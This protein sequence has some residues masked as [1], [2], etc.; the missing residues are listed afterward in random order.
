MDVVCGAP[1]NYDSNIR[2][3][4]LQI[5]ITN[6]IKELKSC[7][8]YQTVTQ[9]HKVSSS[10]GKMG[11]ID[12]LGAQLPQLPICKNTLSGKHSKLKSNKT[13]CACI[14]FAN[15]FCHSVF[16]LT[17]LI[18]SFDGWILIVM[19][20]NLS[21]FLLLLVLLCYIWE[22]I[23]KSKFMKTYMYVPF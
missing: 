6:I 10:V 15:I 9:R 16:L 12:L 14:W 2:G 13:R 11:L 18:V 5:T 20:S 1:N 4:W 22:T 3:H 23:A 19:L 7:E 17:S 21:L 8:N